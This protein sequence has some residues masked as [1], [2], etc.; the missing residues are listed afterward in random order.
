MTLLA[1]IVAPCLSPLLA[2]ALA[3]PAES[4]RLRDGTLV[5]GEIVEFDESS[6][7]TLERADTGGLLTLRWDHLP[8]EE[9][10]RIKESRGFTG[11]DVEPWM[12]SVVHLVLKNGTT[13]T[14]VLVDDGHDD[15]YTLRRR[16]GTD[17][18]PK[19]YVHAVE[20]GRAEG[21]DIYPPEDLYLAILQELGTPVDAPGHFGMAVAS[22][23]ARLYERA[24]EHYTTAAELD[25]EFKPDLIAS[26]VRR[27][28]IKVD[29]AAETEVL[30]EIRRRLFRKQFDQAQEL[31]T[32]F[33]EDFPGSRQLGDLATLE[34]DIA[35]R[36]RQALAGRIISDYFS[37]LD[38]ALSRIART[39]G[40]T[41]GA[42]MEL[43]EEG[44]HEEVVEKLGRSYGV[45]EE[46]IETLWDERR[47]GSVRSSFYGTG[48][49][50][51][52]SDRALDWSVGKGGEEEAEDGAGL[53]EEEEEDL[54]KRI[55]DV[56][57]RRQAEV[58]N[59]RSGARRDR[60]L[61]DAGLTPD[62]WWEQSGTEDRIRWLS[63]YYAEFSGHLEI[64]RAKPRVC[65]L[66]EGQGFI[67]G[68]NELNEIVRDTCPSCKD[69]K[70]ERLVSYR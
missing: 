19:R 52:G 20:S 67:E 18:F 16:S 53:D 51:L 48:T 37:F 2:L 24:R 14:G 59:R 42:A 64:I 6:G 10:K 38:V 45:D 55:E 46:V 54:A 8:A 30:D 26:R 15:T 40:V 43:C 65:R 34:Q 7:F 12:V 47:G 63:A 49:F 44:V 4:V 27:C 21:L 60:A 41:L 70:Y 39:D 69:L 32:E 5:H 61:S 25:P 66:C 9:V 29:E 31:V 35:Q 33:R 36:R 68:V 62:Q 1:L 23:G 58:A 13:E 3:L 17:E 57:R 22:E 11:E 28:D 50:I 56:L